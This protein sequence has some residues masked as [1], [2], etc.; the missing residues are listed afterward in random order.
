MLLS[1]FL[2]PQSVF[3]FGPKPPQPPADTQAWP[4]RNVG[5]AQFLSTPFTL[6]NGVKVDMSTQ[7]PNIMPTEITQKSS[8][9]LRALNEATGARFV[10]KGGLTSFEA[11][12]F[13]NSLT[14]GFKP[15]TG[16]IGSGTIAGATGALTFNVG[17]LDMNF[18]I[19]DTADQEVVGVGQGSAV[20]GGVGLSVSL[21]FTVITTAD[22]FVFQSPMTPVITTA[23]DNALKQ[24]TTDKNT[25][26]QMDWSA[27]VTAV[28]TGAGTLV[29]N[30]GIQSNIQVNNVFNVYDNSGTVIGEV[31]V[32][33][34]DAS[35]AT[36][37]F[38]SDPGGKLLASVRPGDT[39]KIFFLN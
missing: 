26:V 31:K 28:N 1:V 9:R 35:S 11:N 5:L 23:I 2:V 18:Y 10:L 33:S 6:P 15:G 25:N 19:V 39:V 24:M 20:E 22:Q 17:S 13:T 34:V 27:Q 3:A 14:I 30:A 4:T 37:A 8:G 36:A 21:D 7:L 29:F 32:T 16:D 12:N 38:K